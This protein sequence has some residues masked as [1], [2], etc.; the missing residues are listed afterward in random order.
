MRSAINTVL[1]IAGLICTLTLSAQDQTIEFPQG[2]LRIR[3]AFEVIEAQSGLSVAYNE[4][5]LDVNK[6]VAPP[7]LKP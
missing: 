2:K 3:K 6:R 1:V 5:L 7:S 4:D